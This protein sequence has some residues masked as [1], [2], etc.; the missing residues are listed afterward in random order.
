MKRLTYKDNDNSYKLLRGR[1]CQW[2]KAIKEEYSTID[3]S[4]QKLG[5]LEDLEEQIGC[6]I[7]I[8]LKLALK[9]INEIYVEYDDGWDNG[10]YQANVYNIYDKSSEWSDKS[11]WTIETNITEFKVNDYKKTWWLREDKSE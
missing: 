5:K 2:K 1:E 3:N 4:I 7:E 10:L 9:E 11:D 6:P 8:F